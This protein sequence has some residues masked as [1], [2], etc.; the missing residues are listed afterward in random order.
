LFVLI[1]MGI[2]TGGVKLGSFSFQ[3]R[4]LGLSSCLDLKFLFAGECFVLCLALCLLSFFYLLVFC[5]SVPWWV[6]VCSNR[7]FIL[8][9]SF[10]FCLFY[11]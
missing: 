7:S 5:C 6:V 11:M 4:I 1:G 10:S 3:W 2:S 9:F 8:A